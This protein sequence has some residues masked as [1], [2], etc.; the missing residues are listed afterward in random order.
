MKL[1]RDPMRHILHQGEYLKLVEEVKANGFEARM[2]GHRARRG[3]GCA[4]CLSMDRS[5][6]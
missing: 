3:M 6:Q 2:R 4:A 1:A 5:C